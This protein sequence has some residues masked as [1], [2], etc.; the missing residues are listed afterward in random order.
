MTSARLLSSSSSC[1]SLFHSFGGG[2]NK[3]V[4]LALNSSAICDGDDAVWISVIAAR[5]S[6]FCFVFYCAERDAPLLCVYLAVSETHLT[7]K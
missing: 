2:G 3:I 4:V 7:M 5:S 6:F 1:L